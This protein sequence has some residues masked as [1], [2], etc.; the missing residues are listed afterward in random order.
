M[1]FHHRET[2]CLSLSRPNTKYCITIRKYRVQYPMCLVMKA[3]PRDIIMH[4]TT[5]L[6]CN[7]LHSDQVKLKKK[8]LQ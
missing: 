1:Q 6:Y 5:M 7:N 4:S 3:D 8:R 2:T